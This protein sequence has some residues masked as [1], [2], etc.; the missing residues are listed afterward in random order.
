MRRRLTA[1]NELGAIINDC[2]YYDLEPSQLAPTRQAEPVFNL[3]K[4]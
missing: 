3:K 2:A 1:L 4:R